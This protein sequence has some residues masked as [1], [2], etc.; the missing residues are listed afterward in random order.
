M[1]LAKVRSYSGLI[2][3]RALFLDAQAG[4]ADPDRTAR[5]PTTYNVHTGEASALAPAIHLR[6]DS[7][8]LQLQ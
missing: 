7:S 4:F 1:V 2:T 3:L 5:L 8:A 6:A